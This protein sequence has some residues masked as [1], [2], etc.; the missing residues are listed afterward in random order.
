MAEKDVVA[1]EDFPDS[2]KTDNPP[3][4]YYSAYVRILE[5]TGY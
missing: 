3:L 5:G 2:G 1:K 4:K